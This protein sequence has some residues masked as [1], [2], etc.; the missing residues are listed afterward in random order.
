MHLTSSDTCSIIFLCCS[1]GAVAEHGL[2]RRCMYVGIFHTCEQRREV[3]PV[4]KRQVRP[5]TS[6]HA[7]TQIRDDVAKNGMTRSILPKAMIVVRLKVCISKAKIHRVSRTRSLCSFKEK[8]H[9]SP[10]NLLI[11]HLNIL[12][13][14]LLILIRAASTQ[15]NDTRA[16]GW[17]RTWHS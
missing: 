16:P 12:I 11:L 17:R 13:L 1:L 3:Q 2:H 9:Q 8:S 5:P 14:V 10:H 15:I 4:V 6:R 7:S